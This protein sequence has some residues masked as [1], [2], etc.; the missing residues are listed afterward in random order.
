MSAL[1]ILRIVHIFAGV[2][3]VGY[4]LF[5]VPILAP[6]LKRLG[7]TFQVPVMGAL[8]PILTPVMIVNTIVIVGTGIAMTLIL[9][10]GNLGMLFTSGW[11]WMIITGLVLTL[12]AIVLAF[13]FITPA[14]LQAERLGRGIEGR[15]PTP[16]EARQLERLSARIETLSRVN[17]V[18]VILILLTMLLARYV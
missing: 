7:P 9:R 10:Q 1:L 8:M 18:F 15:P 5:M 3:I 4:Y 17:F 14:G 2:F 11:G 6:R 13:G 12:V 16:E